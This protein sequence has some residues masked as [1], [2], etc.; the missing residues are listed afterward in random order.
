[1]SR[2]TDWIVYAADP[3]GS[4]SEPPRRGIAPILVSELVEQADAHG[5]LGALL[6]NF[7]PFSNNLDF[8]LG[9]DI[10]RRLHRINAAFSLMLTRE[11]D[12]LM[13]GV[14]DLPAAIVKGPTFA[15]TIYPE[16]SLRCFG[17]IDVLV[18]PKAV[19]RLNAVLSDRGFFLGEVNLAN[20]RKEWKWLHRSNDRL[21]IEVQTDLIHADSLRRVVSLQY[22]LI[23]AAPEAPAT[24]LL[25]ALVHGSKHKYKKLQ[26][27]VDICQAARALAGTEDECRFEELVKATNARFIAIAGLELAG[28]MFREPHC[29][30][31]ARALGSVRYTGLAGL[32]LGQGVVMSSMNNSRVRHSWRRIAFR[33]LMNRGAFSG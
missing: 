8:A 21:M 32:L 9:R 18:A 15:R 7:P 4:R 27:V 25:I 13:A 19:Q 3:L 28:R 31:I 29:S 30:R 2:L 23:S 24:L 5:V 16:P 14:R 1:L 33:W 12:D 17:D 22:D 26:H 6:R 20:D 11:A 10:A